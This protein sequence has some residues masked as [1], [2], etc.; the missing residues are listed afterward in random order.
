MFRLLFFLAAYTA[1]NVPLSLTTGYGHFLAAY[2]AVNNFA[3]ASF[4]PAIFLAAYDLPP[5]LVPLPS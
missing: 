2:T 4:M 5:V 3:C 1:V